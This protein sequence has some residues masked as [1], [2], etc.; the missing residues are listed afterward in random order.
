[1][2]THRSLKPDDPLLVG[3]LTVRRVSPG[4]KPYLAFDGWCPYCKRD[5]QHGWAE[6]L[7][8]L[9]AVDHRV[10]HCGA[11]P[12]AVGRGYWIG[13][14]PSH[15]EANRR[16]FAEYAA[17]TLPADVPA[18]PVLPSLPRSATVEDLGR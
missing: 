5:H 8:R 17:A 16:A 2:K 13:L 1:M 3:R 11:G 12:L 9:D 10:A 4:G 6:H 7:D 18:G 14:D 15:A